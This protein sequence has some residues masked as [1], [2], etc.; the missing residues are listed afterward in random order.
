M[1]TMRSSVTLMN[2]DKVQR[3]LEKFLR[4][5]KMKDVPI[6]RTTAEILAQKLNEEHQSV[7]QDS[8]EA[9]GRIHQERLETASQSVKYG[10]Q[11][12]ESAEL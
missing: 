5:G 12:K 8:K 6:V 1:A 4:D 10:S 2:A 7:S 11:K 9:N 3:E